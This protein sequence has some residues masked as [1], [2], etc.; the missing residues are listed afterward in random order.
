MKKPS[1]QLSRI[2]PADAQ[3]SKAL[4][5]RYGEEVP[6]VIDRGLSIWGITVGWNGADWLHEP[7][8]LEAVGIE[9]T[10]KSCQQK[11]YDSAALFSAQSLTPSSS[12]TSPSPAAMISSASIEPVAERE[13]VYGVWPK[14]SADLRSGIISLIR[15]M[16]K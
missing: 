2:L 4:Q 8:Q 16:L 9:P 11:G 14:L 5:G 15:T 7:I 13:W 10:D 1:A 12:P 3:S 6:P